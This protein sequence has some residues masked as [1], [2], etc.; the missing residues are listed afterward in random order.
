MLRLRT[1][2]RGR[3]SIAFA[4]LAVVAIAATLAAGPISQ[5]ARGRERGYREISSKGPQV[6]GSG[7]GCRSWPVFPSANPSPSYNALNA[8]AVVPGSSEAWAVGGQRPSS[9]S[10]IPLIEHWNGVAWSVVPDAVDPAVGGFL[11]GV[12]AVST[13]DVWAVGSSG[14]LPLIEHWN[15]STWNVVPSA[16]LPGN[17]DQGYL[18]AVTARSAN[19]VWAVGRYIHDYGG[20]DSFQLGLAEHWDG[21]NWTFFPTPLDTNGNLV[22]ASVSAASANDVWAVGVDAFIKG[23]GHDA[24]IEHWN[25]A[26]WS[27]LPSPTAGGVIEEFQ[28]VVALS[29]TNAWAVGWSS[30]A[31]A[32]QFAKTFVAHWDGKSWTT[33]PSPNVASRNNNLY[34]IAAASANAIWAVGDS[35]NSST[36]Q[37]L[38][39]QWNGSAWTIAPS[40][41]APLAN[42]ALYGVAVGP[43]QTLWAVGQ[44]TLPGSPNNPSTLILHSPSRVSVACPTH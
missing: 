41:N 20:G 34:G 18:F 17:T 6:T 27:I 31:Q 35:T 37:T 40:D 2:R 39:E 23:F 43:Q 3:I 38:V 26:S 8:V 11:Y 1:M 25:G 15:G 22:L 28:G 19:D 36:S 5:A 44:N 13:S 12:T 7:P 33:T 21:V 10:A 30:M 14:P 42:N 24:L 9:T 29:A 4:I 16:S 32:G